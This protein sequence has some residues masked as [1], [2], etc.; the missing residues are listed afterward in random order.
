[1]AAVEYRVLPPGSPAPW[2]RQRCTSNERY[3]FDTAAGRS[4]LLC[5]FGLMAG[6]PGQT[7][8]AAALAMRSRFDDDHL[9]LFGVSI[10]PGDEKQARL[11]ASMPGV[12]HFWGFDGR[13][14]TASATR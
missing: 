7:R 10:E 2:F 13:S 5:F 12:R 11:C 1:M 3:V 4:V 14:W 6:S 8:M 9:A